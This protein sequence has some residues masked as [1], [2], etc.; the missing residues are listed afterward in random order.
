MLWV[1]DCSVCSVSG[2]WPGLAQGSPFGAV[3]INGF[4]RDQHVK[5]AGFGLVVAFTKGSS[6][7]SQISFDILLFFDKNKSP[8]CHPPHCFSFLSPLCFCVL[9]HEPK[10]A[11]GWWDLCGRGQR[12]SQGGMGGVRKP[13]QEQPAFLVASDLVRPGPGLCLSFVLLPALLKKVSISIKR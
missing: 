11:R 8:G 9:T 13:F 1:C 3:F 4:P 7:S 12:G 10:L 6:L 5:T 2:T